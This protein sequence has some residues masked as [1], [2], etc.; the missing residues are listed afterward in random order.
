MENETDTCNCKLKNFRTILSN[1]IYGSAKIIIQLKGKVM[2]YCYFIR[3][4]ERFGISNYKLFDWFGTH[5]VW[6]CI[7]ENSPH[8]HGHYTHMW[9][10]IGTGSVNER[11]WI[12]NIYGQLVCPQKHLQ[13]TLPHENQRVR[14]IMK[15]RGSHLNLSWM[16]AT[17]KWRHCIQS[18]REPKSCVL[19][20][21]T[22]SMCSFQHV[23][24]ICQEK[25]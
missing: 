24:S 23:H 16:F 3:K 1:K 8:Y 20:G 15:E 9:N 19:E 25:L 12:Q 5:S 2:F 14:F 22:R 21:Q 6:V 4:C 11:V 17:E 10:C 7:L 18:T 13:Q